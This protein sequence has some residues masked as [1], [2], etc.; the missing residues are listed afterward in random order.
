M[1]TR[2]LPFLFAIALAACAGSGPQRSTPASAAKGD[3][4]TWAASALKAR[5]AD[6]NAAQ[7]LTQIK[8]ATDIAPDRADLAWL[9][10][11]LCMEVPGCEPEPLEA[12]LRKL[13]PANGAVWL[14]VLSRTQARRDAQA[15]QQIL[16]AMSRAERFDVYWT[17]LNSHLAVALN[18]GTS[19]ASTQKDPLTTSL[20][21]VT[22]WLSGLVVLAFKPVTSACDRQRARDA[23]AVQRCQDIAQAMQRSDT[24]LV[25]ALGL[26]M[27]QR[28]A[29]PGTSAAAEYD[30]HAA[31]LAYL[32]QASGS[33]IQ[34]QV[35]R[36]KFSTQLIELMKKLRREQE[37]SA[38]ILRWAGQPLEPPPGGR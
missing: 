18:A 11:R 8:R 24:T 34:A 38:A 29:T 23:A 31:R 4:D 9:H 17:S 22:D 12:R 7:A 35:E 21:S 3:A 32:S 33:I 19:A 30:R 25:E 26:G 37:V 1:K 16:D 15:E 36:E 28:F 27:A 6:R 5:S 10:V 2:L 20:N 14:G 13:D